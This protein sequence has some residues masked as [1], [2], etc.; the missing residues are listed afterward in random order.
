M[1]YNQIL[2]DADFCIKLGCSDSY[3]YLTKMLQLLADVALIH[4]TVYNEIR[5]STSAK[6]QIKSLLD[7]GTL[8]IV[9]EAV[10][11]VQEQLLYHATFK[12]LSKRMIDPRY[13][14]KNLGEVSSLAYAKTM[15]IAIFATDEMHLQTIVDEL[16]NTELH[17]ITC[18]RII[19]IIQAIKARKIQLLQRKDAKLLWIISAKIKEA[20]DPKIWPL[21][22]QPS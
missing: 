5:Q 16:L 21:I 6:R 9:S 1:H 2:V 18:L 3:P 17:K 4:E 15:D 20:F 10:L 7:S 13:P 19:D 14:R 8:K 22:Q 11:P 12:L